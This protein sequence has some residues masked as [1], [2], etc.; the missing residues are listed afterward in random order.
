MDDTSIKRNLLKK[1]ISMGITQSEMAERLGMSITAYRK[2]EKGPTRMLNEHLEKFSE[3]VGITLA[4]LVNGF[5]PIDSVESGLDEM[6]VSYDSKLESIQKNYRDEIQVLRKE[7]E[8][9]R[10]KL[11]D[12]EE[13]LRTKDQLIAQ[14][15]LLIAQYNKNKK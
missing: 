12:K 11:A 4:E 2:L 7:N 14:C 8:R 15:N 9:L 13:L 10:D 3:V 6:K 5:E 1:R